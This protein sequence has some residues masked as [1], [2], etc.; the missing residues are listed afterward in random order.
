MRGDW[1]NSGY[2]M[3]AEWE[4]HEGTWLQW[5]RDKVEPGYQ[6]KQEH[7]WLKMVAALCQHETVHVITCDER[8]RDHVAYQLD[9]FGIDH[10]G[11]EHQIIPVD[12]VWARDNGPIFVKDDHG[13]L[14]I[15]DWTFNGWGK[16]FDHELDNKVPAAIGDR[17][18]I[19]VVEPPMVLEGGAVEVNGQGTFMATRSSIMDT[20]RNPGRSQTEIEAILSKYLGVRHFIWLEGAGRGECEKWGDTTDSHIDI[21]ARFTNDSTILYNWTECQSDPRYPMFARHLEELK[22]ATTESG[23]SPTLVPLPVPKDGV[24]QVAKDSIWRESRYTDAAYSNYLVANGVVLVPVFGNVNDDRAKQIIG[25]Q[26][27][28]R[29]IV[30]IDAV[31]LTEDGGAIHCV[32]QQQPVAGGK[33]ER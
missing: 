4:P 6:M 7:T 19:P 8:Q 18:G 26:F 2:T 31:S 32:T 1:A 16:R 3:P 23:Q 14:V 27:P 25:E 24:Y 17:L 15:T 5:P 21:A 22:A 28:D 13:D 30:A 11:I 33:D 20:H 12:D 29:E 9:Y 10:S